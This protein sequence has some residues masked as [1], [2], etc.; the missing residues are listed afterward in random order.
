MDLFKTMHIYF[1]V[2]I[3]QKQTSLL[4]V[5]VYKWQKRKITHEK[6]LNKPVIAGVI[7][8]I[9]PITWVIGACRRWWSSQ[10]DGT[11]SNLPLLW[12]RNC[13]CTCLHWVI[14]NQWC[15]RYGFWVNQVLYFMLEDIVIIDRVPWR[16]R[17]LLTT[18]IH[19]IPGR[20]RYWRSLSYSYL[21][22]WIPEKM[23]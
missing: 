16:S 19:I 4:Q 6:W 13:R 5:N 10:I 2:I 22:Q 7:N 9:P 8:F 23:S 11:S 12:L 20:K 15:E 14:W 17:V 21:N 3:I 1:N 18:D